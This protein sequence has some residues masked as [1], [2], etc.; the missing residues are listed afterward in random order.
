MPTNTRFLSALLDSGTNDVGVVRRLISAMSAC[1]GYA[2][3][4]DIDTV[5]DAAQA[6]SIAFDFLCDFIERDFVLRGLKEG[7]SLFISAFLLCVV[8]SMLM[9]DG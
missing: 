8:L 7:R 5:T 4:R 1:P 9:L 2:R 6:R 3:F